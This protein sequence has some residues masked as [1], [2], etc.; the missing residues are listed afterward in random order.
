MKRVALALSIAILFSVQLGSSCADKD[1]RDEVP[2]SGAGPVPCSGDPVGTN[3]SNG[4]FLTAA[5]VSQIVGQAV[6]EAQANGIPNATITIV[7]RVNN[8]LA[9]WQM[10]PDADPLAPAANN[11]AL[12]TT[13]GGTDSG[14]KGVTIPNTLA[15]ISKAGTSS[16]FSTQANAFSTR[17][18]SQVI[19]ENFNPGEDY[20]AAGPLFGVQFSQL[21]CNPF[22]QRFDADALQGPKRLPVGFAGDT[23]AVSLYRQGVAVGAVAVEFDGVYDLDQDILS[24]DTDLEERVAVAGSYCFQAPTLRRA[25]NITIDGRS[26]RFVEDDGLQTQPDCTTPVGLPATGSLVPVT[27][28]FGNFEA[29]GLLP[30]CVGGSTPGVVCSTAAPCGGVGTCGVPAAPLAGTPLIDPPAN[31]SGF[32]ETVIDSVLNPD[33]GARCV[34]NGIDEGQGVCATILIDP[35]VVPRYPPTASTLPLPAAGGLSANEVQEILYQVL[36]VAERTRAQ[37]RLPIGEEARIDVAVVDRAGEILGVAR[38]RDA[39][40]DG[41]NVVIQ[42]AQTVAFF[43]DDPIT[44][45]QAA[46]DPLFNAA[47]NPLNVQSFTS[48]GTALQNFFDGGPLPAGTAFSTTAIGALA[49]PY[50]PAGQNGNSPGPL[51]RDF[52]S[53]SIFSTGFESD[54]ILSGVAAALCRQVPELRAVLEDALGILIPAPANCPLPASVISCTNPDFSTITPAPG[55][56]S[57][58]PQFNAIDLGITLFPGGFPIYRGNQLIGGV[59][60][61]GDGVEQN[62]LIAILGLANAGTNAGTGFGNAPRSIR[63]NNLDAQGNRVRYAICAVS[64]FLDDPQEQAACEDL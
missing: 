36:K 44:N 45:L 17:T 10:Q 30:V 3:C 47:G 15:A 35:G 24:D 4:Q 28:W 20:R 22:S 25:N 53:W 32:F 9:V 14:L 26:L 59:G 60:V 38:S 49:Q 37:A 8:V 54:A 34:V 56:A 23:G 40:V 5:E 12:V 62:D 2:G 55:P 43:S 52:D 29:T 42:K 27:G 18:T 57:P 6:A 21:P 39:L 50:Y 13:S 51:S 41:L 58:I 11:S 63:A 61:S 16:F 46:A 64:P 31:A 19:Q 7:D 48:Y 33:P 1:G